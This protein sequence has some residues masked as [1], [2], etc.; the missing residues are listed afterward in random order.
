M[1]VLVNG[2]RR[3]ITAL[4]IIAVAFYALGIIAAATIIPGGDIMTDYEYFEHHQHG[5]CAVGCPI[6]AGEEMTRLAAMQRRESIADADAYFIA[7]D[8]LDRPALWRIGD[9]VDE[10]TLVTRRSDWADTA[11]WELLEVGVR[12][13]QAAM[14]E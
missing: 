6:C 2:S 14:A 1:R 13:M 7:P 9:S 3:K 8:Q 12:V 4:L 10:P 11:A 5:D